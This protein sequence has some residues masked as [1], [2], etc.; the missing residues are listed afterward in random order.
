M[1]AIFDFADPSVS[2]PHHV[3]PNFE[4]LGELTTPWR[5]NKAGS[6]ELGEWLSQARSE[7]DSGG[8][9]SLN[10]TLPEGVSRISV[11]LDD[12]KNPKRHNLFYPFLNH[13]ES[14]IAIHSGNLRSKNKTHKLAQFLR[15]KFTSIDEV[16]GKELVSF[17]KKLEKETESNERLLLIIQFAKK[18]FNSVGDALTA[19]TKRGDASKLTKSTKYPSI[20]IAAN[21]YLKEANSQNLTLLINSIKDVPITSLYRRDMLN[22]FIKILRIHIENPNFSLTE[23]SQ[24]FQRDFRHSGRP[25]S[26]NKLIGTTLLVKGLE[27]DHA[28]ILAADTMTPKEL[29][30]ALTR[31]AKSITI[32]S[33]SNRIPG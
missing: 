21:L 24:Q 20:L 4:K 30:V 11:D 1:Q 14:V 13:N 29:Y 18:C 15:G 25:V 22:R 32:V 31:G 3:Y 8:K 28:I 2:W 19:A 6:I 7:L 12:F 27:Y 17:I 10:G 16:E 5:W 23:S 9:I 26:Y 33:Q